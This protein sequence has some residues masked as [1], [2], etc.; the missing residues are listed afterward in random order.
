LHR[1]ERGAPSTDVPTGGAAERYSKAIDP[2]GNDNATVRIG[3][4][5]LV[6]E[7]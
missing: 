5:G 6:A 1:A 3:A 7:L 2:L 4:P